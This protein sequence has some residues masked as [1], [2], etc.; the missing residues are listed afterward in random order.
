[1]GEIGQL[2]PLSRIPPC[3]PTSG[4]GQGNEAPKRKPATEDRQPD[5][6][7]QQRKKNDDDAHIDEYA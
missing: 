5:D 3:T 4:T 1:M 6:G 2:P 7:R